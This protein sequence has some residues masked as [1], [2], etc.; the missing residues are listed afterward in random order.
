MNCAVDVHTLPPQPNVLRRPPQP[1]GEGDAR[2][3]YPPPLSISRD[4]D[5]DEYCDPLLMEPPPVGPTPIQ[6]APLRASFWPVIDN[7]QWRPFPLYSLLYTTV[8]NTGLPNHMVSRITVPS[9]LN[10]DTWDELLKD[11]HDQDLLKYLRFGWPVGFTGSHPPPPVLK[12]HTSAT[13]FPDQIS[14]F[15]EK[16]LSLGGLLGPFDSP[17]FIPWTSVAPL[18]T[19][20]KK[21][22]SDRRVVLDLSFPD[23]TG[24]NG[25]ITKNCLEGKMCGYTLPTVEDLTT[26]IKITGS[27]C[28]LWKADMAR[29]YR[30]LRSEPSDLPLLGLR[31]DNKYY[32]D[33]CPSFGARLSSSACQRTTTAIVYLMALKGHWSTVYLDDFCG[34][35]SSR[36]EADQAYTDFLQLCRDLGI[37]LS[38]AKCHPPTQSL[39]WLGFH[40]NTVDMTLRVP[41]IKLKEVEQ[42]CMQWSKVRFAHKNKIQSLVGKIIHISKCIPPARRFVCRILETLR[43]APTSAPAFLTNGFLLDVKWFLNYARTTNGLHFLT[44][45]KQDFEIECDSTLQWGGGNSNSHYYSLEYTDDQKS[46]FPLIVHREAVNLVIAYRT[47]SPPPIQGSQHSGVH[48]QY[49]L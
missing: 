38:P 41:N 40:F 42:E 27:S 4:H 28:F 37:T 26:K 29:A 13:R 1:R 7:E 24:I 31:F 12:N 14:S 8:S 30:Q 39:E 35:A 22:S 36:V 32:L 23:G 19:T 16:E 46:K 18:L 44:F 15:V 17:P 6:Y 5:S 45:P 33:L 3:P 43:K 48:R 11:Y 10:L 34:V 47:L 2:P 25:S 20:K 9:G 49:D 21:D